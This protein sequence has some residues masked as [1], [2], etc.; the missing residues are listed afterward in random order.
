MKRAA[1]W[2]LKHRRCAVACLTC[3][4]LHVAQ[5][6]VT[7]GSSMPLQPSC[8]APIVYC[9]YAVSDQHV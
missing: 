7:Q 6:T 8:L 3:V 5:H 2:K 1:Q 4:R 9:R